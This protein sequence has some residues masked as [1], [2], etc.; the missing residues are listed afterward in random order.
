MALTVAQRQVR[1]EVS[2]ESAQRHA[3]CETLNPMGTS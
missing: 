3:L 1:E 2:D